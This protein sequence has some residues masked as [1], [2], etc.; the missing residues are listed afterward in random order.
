M[1]REEKMNNDEI[2]KALIDVRKAYRLVYLYTASILDAVQR[3]SQEFNCKFYVWTPHY[4]S[5]SPRITTSPFPPSRW[6]WDMI[7]FYN[8]LFLFLYEGADSNTQK[9]GDW[10]L[11]ISIET[12][13]SATDKFSEC[14]EEPNPL[15][16]EPPEKAESNLY[17][18]FYYCTQSNKFNWY[19][20]FWESIDYP[21]EEVD[22]IEEYGLKYVERTY[23]SSKL[24]TEKTL[25]ECVADFKDAVKKHV[26][27]VKEL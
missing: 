19:Y 24:F 6:A 26:S 12:D 21:D 14:E 23:E 16:F 17:L 7:P 15:D 20:D 8:P 1:K 3:I 5:N 10:M 11:E 27:E 4:Y 22:V 2:S 13:S 25:L 9:K 18:R